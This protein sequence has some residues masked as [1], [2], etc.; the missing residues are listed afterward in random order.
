MSNTKKTH[1]NSIIELT[2]EQLD[3]V[4]GGAVSIFLRIDDIE[5]E[6]TRAHSGGAGKASVKAL[7]MMKYVD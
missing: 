4:Y 7:N 5:G 1:E 3:S 6:S 2:D